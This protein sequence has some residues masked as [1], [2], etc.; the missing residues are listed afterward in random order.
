MARSKHEK[1]KD[2]ETGE[3]VSRES[4]ELLQGKCP[5]FLVGKRKRKRKRR[6]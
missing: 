1:G 5:R 2:T 4:K 6:E 3:R